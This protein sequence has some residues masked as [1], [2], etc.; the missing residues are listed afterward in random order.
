MVRGSC[1]YAQVLKKE[2][3]DTG[4]ADWVNIAKKYFYKPGQL[5]RN[6][7][8]PLDQKSRATLYHYADSGIIP[9]E[10]S[11]SRR[12]VGCDMASISEAIAEPTMC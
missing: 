11:S 8:F 1:V 12:M 10:I 7:R 9:V 5:L 2:L 4:I 3:L 6:V